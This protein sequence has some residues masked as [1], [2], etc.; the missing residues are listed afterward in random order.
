MGLDVICESEVA[1]VLRK[2]GGGVSDNSASR[3]CG[4]LGD[5]AL[6]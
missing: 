6:F 3:R 4:A 2:K 5:R 1:P